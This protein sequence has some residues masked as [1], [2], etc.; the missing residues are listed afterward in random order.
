MSPTDIST[1]QPTVNRVRFDNSATK[2]V[3][4]I[5]AT[6]SARRKGRTTK[7]HREVFGFYL[8]PADW[9][10]RAVKDGTAGKDASATYFAL[11]HRICD[12]AGLRNN[13]TTFRKL[14]H[15]SGVCIAIADKASLRPTPRLSLEER[16][17][18]VKELLKT[19]EEPQM[20]A[21]RVDD[22]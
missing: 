6:T 13:D 9:H 7:L 10:K 3:T 18:V 14:E 21:E 20:Y 17:R 8:S 19:D 22:R 2:T 1:L 4:S 5:A 16:I 15:K 11:R 12:T